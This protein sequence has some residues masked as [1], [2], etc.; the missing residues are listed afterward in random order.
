VAQIEFSGDDLTRR[1]PLLGQFC[2]DLIAVVTPL[3]DI[4]QC[5]WAEGDDEMTMQARATIFDLMTKYVLPAYS[6]LGEAVGMQGDKLGLVR[7]IGDQ[8][9]ATNGQSAG[10]TGGGRHG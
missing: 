6:L 10:W 7:L 1:V 5:Q 4:S 8:T 9:E 2:D 3:I